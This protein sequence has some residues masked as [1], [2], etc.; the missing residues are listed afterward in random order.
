M[1]EEPRFAAA[2]SLFACC[3]CSL[4]SI[5]Y[6]TFTDSQYNNKNSISRSRI[7]YL[8]VRKRQE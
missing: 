1:T 8:Y 7:N 5:L 6:A 4:L 2:A 3:L